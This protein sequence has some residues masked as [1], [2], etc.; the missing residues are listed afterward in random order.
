MLKI[1]EYVYYTLNFACLIPS[2]NCNQHGSC[3]IGLNTTLPTVL[4]G[5]EDILPGGE[6]ILP[7]GED[8]IIK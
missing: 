1:E 7:G 4:P 2:L 3:N 6:D 8:N 5:G